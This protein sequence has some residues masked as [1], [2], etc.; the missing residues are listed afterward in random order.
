MFI[1]FKKQNSKQKGSLLFEMLI[2]ISLVAILISVG[3]N[4][5]FLS[6]RSNKASGERDTAN[7]LASIALESVR[8]IAEENWLNIYG[9]TK[10]GQR[11]YPSEVD[12]KWVLIEG[13]EIININDISYTRY[14]T[15]DNVSRDPTT[16]DI[17]SE[18][19]LGNDDPS[20]QKATVVVNW[21]QGSPVV[22]SEYFYRWRNKICPQTEWTTAES[23]DSV[24]NCNTIAYDEK[25]STIDT[26]AGS[27]KLASAEVVDVAVGDSYG[28]GIVAY[29]LQ[30]GDPGYDS[31]TQHGLIAAP[32]NQADGAEVPW[33]CYGTFLSGANGNLLGAGNQNTIDILAGCG[34][35]SIAARYCADLTLGGYSD[36]YLPS[37]NEIYKLYLNQ[38]AIGGF[39]NYFW[40]S[41]QRD[42][43]DAVLQYFGNGNSFY[44]SKS[45]TAYV[46]AVRSF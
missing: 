17:E 32:T 33:G 13:D 23:G 27:L 35:S 34:E 36:W 39:V 9:L 31:S 43:S 41:T 40:S 45:N 18:Y 37:E 16:K 1:N 44:S 20:T 21:S 42:A 12:G 22:V 10:S 19:I 4:A 5:V 29:I 6:M 2:V 3:A 25:E 7:G 15:I 38:N 46:R 30:E 28:G 11:Y 14:L 24:E 8:S 26:S